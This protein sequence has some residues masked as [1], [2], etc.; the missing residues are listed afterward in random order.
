MMRVLF[1]CAIWMVLVTG[2]PSLSKSVM[3]NFLKYLSSQIAKQANKRSAA[4]KREKKQNTALRT[5]WP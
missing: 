2:K 3:E 5:E 4:E 1:A